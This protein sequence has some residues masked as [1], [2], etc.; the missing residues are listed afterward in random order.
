MMCVLLYALC[1]GRG[2][3]DVTV[4]CRTGIMIMMMLVVYGFFSGCAI[5]VYFRL[6]VCNTV[7][8]TMPVDGWTVTSSTASR[9]LSGVVK[10]L[11]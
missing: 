6:W 7:I 10:V 9:G 1:R 3:Y 4:A 2:L 8:G 11:R 5:C